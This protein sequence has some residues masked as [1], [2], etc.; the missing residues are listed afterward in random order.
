M[1][2]S[3]TLSRASLPLTDDKT[4]S[5]DYQIFQVREQQS[6]QEELEEIDMEKARSLSQTVDLR[7]F[8]TQQ[9]IIP[10]CKR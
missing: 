9:P 1:Y 4:S 2:I 8:D 3:D 5:A 7:K 10:L 6:F